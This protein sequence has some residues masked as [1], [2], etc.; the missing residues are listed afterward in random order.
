MALL[1]DTGEIKS[2]GRI[3]VLRARRERERAREGRKRRERERGGL[4]GRGEKVLETYLNDIFIYV[5]A[6]LC[7]T[8]AGRA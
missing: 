5:Y 8:K 3:K 1:P 4:H 2:E 6:S 7:V